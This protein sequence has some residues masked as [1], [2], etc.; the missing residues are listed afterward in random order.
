MAKFNR[1]I[2]RNFNANK[3]NRIRYD[4]DNFRCEI[5]AFDKT[6]EQTYSPTSIGSNYI[7]NGELGWF[8]GMRC[9][10]SVYYKG[11]G[12]EMDSELG[13]TVVYEAKETS[14][15][16]RLELLFANRHKVGKDA[17]IDNTLPPSIKLEIGDKPIKESMTPIGTDVN[18]S[19]YYHYCKME[20]GKNLIHYTLSPNTIFLGLVIKKYNKWEASRDNNQNDKLTMIKATVEHTKELGINTMTAEFMYYHLLDEKLLPTDPNAN[21]SGLVFDYR[22]EINLYVNDTNGIPKQVF[23]GYISTCEVDSDLEKITMECADRLID[24]DRRYCLSEVTLNMDN[25]STDILYNGYYDYKKNYHNYSAPLKFL[26]N[27]SEIYLNT[28]ISVGN[29]LIKNKTWKLAKYRNKGYN[30]FTKNNML[31]ELN[32]DSIMIRNGA[33]TLKPQSL[34]IYDSS[35]LNQTVELNKY[36]NLFMHYGLGEERWEEK[37]KETKTVNVESSSIKASKTWIER[38]NSITKKTGNDAIKPIFNYVQKK[39]IYEYRKDFYQSA[40]T[41]WSRKRGNC[42]C[43]AELLLTLLNAKGVTGLQY[44]HRKVPNSDKG[45]VYTKVNGFVLDPVTSKGWGDYAKGYGVVR[46]TTDFPTKPF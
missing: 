8:H 40:S 38:A 11:Y 28:N 2:T 41:T 32:N 3:T 31:V 37:V 22:D 20:K 7:E 27:N 16:Y 6:Y 10:Q 30:K 15:N 46:K 14:D 43:Q 44:V 25:A 13:I 24:L 29:P 12:I 34:V 19:R 23:G 35:K 4:K 1:H 33:D 18:F 26:M 45:H 39:V 42:C 5:L 36:P 9:L 21:R 17:E